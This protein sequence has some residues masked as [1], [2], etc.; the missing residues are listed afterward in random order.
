MAESTVKKQTNIQ[1][2]IGM[3]MTA[4][5]DKLKAHKD[6]KSMSD[7]LQKMN[8]AVNGTSPFIK[9]AYFL[10]YKK[11]NEDV[12]A[13]NTSDNNPADDNPDKTKEE[14]VI[15]IIRRGWPDPLKKAKRDYKG[16]DKDDTNSPDNYDVPDIDTYKERNKIT[17]YSPDITI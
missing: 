11:A 16:P 17:K 14:F 13:S 8:D 2:P 3:E 4:V 6:K 9:K 7:C 12:S 10:G 1:S 15:D 5:I